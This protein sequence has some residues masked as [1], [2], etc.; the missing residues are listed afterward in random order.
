MIH[1]KTVNLNIKPGLNKT[2]NTLF[3][4]ENAHAKP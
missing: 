2:S 4:L 3:S 1:I